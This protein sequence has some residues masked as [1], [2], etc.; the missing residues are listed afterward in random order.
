MYLFN[1]EDVDPDIT[2]YWAVTPN[3]IQHML[4]MTEVA[5][6]EFNTVKA[7]QQ[8]KLENYM[9][10]NFFWSNLLD[11]DSDDGTC[12]RTVAWAKD[13]MIL[14][15]IAEMNTKVD[16]LPTKKYSTGIYSTFDLGA[17]R[18]EGAKVHECLNLVTQTLAA[19]SAR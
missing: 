12:K 18:M 16:I 4:N 5:S 10:F 2:K 8:G 15:T 6:A 14:A 3:C 1:N 13:G 17:V 11:W 9:G 19:S 7:L